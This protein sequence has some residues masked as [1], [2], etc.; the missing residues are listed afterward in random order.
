[1][2]VSVI[3]P[4]Y[5]YSRYV[6]Q[7]IGAVLAQTLPATEIVVV[8]DGS[9]DDTAAEV[10][11]FG[12]KVRYIKQE[13]AGVCVARNR[14]VADS[15]GKYIAFLD[16]DDIWEPEKLAKQIAKFSEDDQIGLVHCGMREFHSDTGETI[17]MHLQGTE[18]WVADDLLLW[19][20]LGVIGP[21]GTIIV[22]RDAFE[23]VGG[24]DESLKV[25]EDWDFCYRIARKY[26]V[27]FV[28]ELLVNYRNHGTNAHK[29]VA[30]MERGMGRFYQRAFDT[31]DANVL[32]LKRRAYGN[33]HRVLSGSYFQ[34][35]NY[36]KFIEHAMRSIKYR[37][38][39]LA[40]FLKFPFRRLG[41]SK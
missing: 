11:K 29:N 19:E 23:N 20:G 40:Y 9:T 2:T 3:I 8:D 26:K 36:K 4:T 41:R 31:D 6:G 15:T 18:G 38:A 21:G 37:P 17:A 13:N 24:F 1:M 34:S 35:K 22:R 14:G 7:A 25:G 30:E 5:N 16:A 10:E 32:H 12:E 27:G 28:P 39:N 33:Y